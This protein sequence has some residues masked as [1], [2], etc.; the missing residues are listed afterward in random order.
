MGFCSGCVVALCDWR[1]LSCWALFFTSRKFGVH[2]VQKQA[3]CCCWSF[4]LLNFAVF[5]AFVYF[6][7]DKVR[8]GGDTIFATV[9]GLIWGLRIL[10]RV[11]SG[12]YSGMVVSGRDLFSLFFFWFFFEG[13]TYSLAAMEG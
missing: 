4:F 2:P 1:I 3:S 8:L 6:T 7:R 11:P 5:P 13:K 9:L 10:G 12:R